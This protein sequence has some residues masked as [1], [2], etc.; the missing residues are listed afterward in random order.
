MTREKAKILV[1][2]LFMIFSPYA[3]S[4]ELG[5][6]GRLSSP[7]QLILSSDIINDA[8]ASGKAITASIE[9][10]AMM[11]SG[12][13][14]RLLSDSDSLTG[15]IDSG[16]IPKDV[17]SLF[18]PNNSSNFE[19]LFAFGNNLSID[20]MVFNDLN[21]DGL[22]TNDEPGLPNW[23]VILTQGRNEFLRNSTDGSGHYSFQNLAVGH[24]S[25]ALVN[26]SG[27]NFT[28]P[29]NGF[30]EINLVDINASNYDFG[31]HFGPVTFE[32]SEYPSMPMEQAIADAEAFNRSPKFK[33]KPETQAMLKVGAAERFSLLGNLQYTAND[34]TQ[35]NCENCWV[36]AS[37]ACLENALTVQEGIKDRLS[38]QYFVSNYNGGTGSW[39]C[40]PGNP[41][42]FANFYTNT[43]K[44]A[45]PWSN[46][47]ANWRDTDKFCTESTST[48]ANQIG[49]NPNYP[50]H[51]MTLQL[52]IETIGEGEAN[53]IA[54]IKAA[55]KENKMV[56]FA[57]YLPSDASWNEFV[58]Y[59][60]SNSGIYDPDDYCGQSISD[61]GHGHAVA[62]VG[63]DD[64]SSDPNQHYWIML[65]SWGA[66][67]AHSDGTFK[68]KMHMNYDCY[69]P[70]W[71]YAHTFWTFDVAFSPWTRLGGSVSSKHSAITDNQGRRHVFVTGG[72]NALWDNVDGYW[73]RLGGALTSA[74]Y[75]AKDK[76]GRIHIVARGGD[77]ALWDFILDTTNWTGT[78]RGLGG[79]LSSMAT[80]AMEPTYDTWMKIVARGGDNALWLCEFNVNDLSSYN[81]V[82][83]GGVLNSWPFVIFDQNSRMHT[84]AAGGD[85]ALWDNRGVLSSGSYVHN[86]HGLGGVINLPPYATLEP[87]RA[88]YIAAM[89]RGSDDAL[90]MASINGISDPETCTWDRLGGVISSDAFAATD[91]ANRIHTF[92]RG[93][94]GTMWE[95]VFSSSPWNPSGAQWIG[96]GGYLNAWSPQ[97][98]IGSQT[99]AYVLGGDNAIWRKVY[100]TSV[101]SAASSEAEANGKDDSPA[102]SE[103][104]V[105]GGT[106]ASIPMS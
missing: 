28:S 70:G 74:P 97:A 100:A 106:G 5:Q 68:V 85:D 22:R 103:G 79:Y 51:L 25:I 45:I 30:Y 24:Y 15:L 104:M 86:W 66:P 61:N 58:T 1:I 42:I 6:R 7:G 69:Y 9:T 44:K 71:T 38:V 81:W 94:D 95:N 20:G 53:A 56:F 105:A 88:N 89:V 96:H 17:T 77:Y 3:L 35:V 31:I 14:H 80:A 67:S 63:W 34:R 39:A 47:K 57:F 2:L 76:N 21:G 37:T 26:Q 84:L 65:N 19:H 12:T 16:A 11:M 52:G 92:V 90:W 33:A 46:V 72:D 4:E 18:L 54:N 36:W 49:T 23:E 55:L 78:W 87:G 32:Q 40:C 29:T 43:L 27:W 50:L 99:C 8:N 62:C 75:S 98:L 93:S 10:A 59:W 64:T 48:P 13:D 60:N 73:I 82:G 91:N 102:Q 101:A 41:E 83:L